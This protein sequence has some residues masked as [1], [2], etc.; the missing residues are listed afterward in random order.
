[1]C[2]IGGLMPQQIAIRSRLKIALIAR[3][4]FFTDR[5]R[6]GAVGV[7]FLDGADDIADHVIREVRILAALQD[8]GAVAQRIALLAAGE[9]LLLAQPIALG[10]LVACPESA[11]QTIVLA[12]GGE[13]DQAAQVHLV[14][15]PL[16]AH[17]IRRLGQRRVMRGTFDQLLELLIAEIPILS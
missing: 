11:V 2:G 6:Y 9:D 17:L 16:S 3:A 7:F 15:V 1:M 10:V 5:E 13:L 14:A 8:K 4:R 12:V